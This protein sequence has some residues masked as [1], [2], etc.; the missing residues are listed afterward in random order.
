MIFVT[1]GS[2]EPFD[3]LLRALPI[4]TEEALL[5]QTGAS[6]IRPV[7]A[8]CVPFMTFDEITNAIAA[9]RVVISH[10]GVGTVLTALQ[11]GKRPV[12][13]PRRR[14]FS[15]AVDDHQVELAYRLAESGLA[16]VIEDPVQLEH[17]LGEARTWSAV[18]TSSESSDLVKDLGDYIA[19]V[20]TKS[21]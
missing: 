11:H 1:V 10:A 6:S 14:R 17:V 5:V 3:R 20:L 21:N 18:P 15:E 16:I 4:P 2:A 19:S 7:G 9:A 8:T 13:V 12:L